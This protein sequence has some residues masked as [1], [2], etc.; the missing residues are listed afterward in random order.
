MPTYADETIS[1]DQRERPQA[2]LSDRHQDTVNKHAYLTRYRRRFI[3]Q[4]ID[5]LFRGGSGFD[6][7]VQARIVCR[8]TDHISAQFGHFRSTL[9]RLELS[10]AGIRQLL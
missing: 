9:K 2:R 4:A 1:G 5:L 8:G 7:G 10:V 3:A 6:A